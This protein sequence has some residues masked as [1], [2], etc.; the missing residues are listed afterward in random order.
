MSKQ[1]SY[2]KASESVQTFNSNIEDRGTV[3][4]RNNEENKSDLASLSLS[5]NASS[6]QRKAAYKEADVTSTES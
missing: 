1:N 6:S 3:N 5:K 2:S 4:L